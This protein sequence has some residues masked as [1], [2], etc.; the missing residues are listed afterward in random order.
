MIARSLLS[1]GLA[2]SMNAL[3]SAD[4]RTIEQEFDAAK[5]EK[6]GVDVRVGELRVTAS[7]DD[8]LHVAV[9]VCERRGWF[10]WRRHKAADA[11]LDVDD[12]EE[13]IALAIKQKHYTEDWTVR[14]P[15]AAALDADVGVGDVTIEGLQGDIRLDVGVGDAEI[16]GKAADYGRVSGDAGVGDVHVSSDSGESH[17]ERA[18]VS[19]SVNW[20]AGGKSSISADLGV[21]DADITLD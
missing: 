17:T 12:D 14:M 21:G 2:V 8:K 5:L 15:A 1:L 20:I 3:A 7:D 9:E 6:I 11:T 10:G 13:S 18:L 19:D 16:R 4:C